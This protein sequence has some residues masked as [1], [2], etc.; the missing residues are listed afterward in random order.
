M[1]C[2]SEGAR[3]AQVLVRLAEGSTHAQFALDVEVHLNSVNACADNVVAPSLTPDCYNSL[4]KNRAQTRFGAV[5][6]FENYSKEK[7]LIGFYRF[8]L[9][10][11]QTHQQLHAGELFFGHSQ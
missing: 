3:R 4:A 7:H 10:K 1:A 5:F 9:K 6:L 11:R 2:L 8:F